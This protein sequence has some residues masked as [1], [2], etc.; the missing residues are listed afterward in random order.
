VAITPVRECCQNTLNLALSEAPR[1][2]TTI[3]VGEM[4]DKLEDAQK[5]LLLSEHYMELLQTTASIMAAKSLSDKKVHEFISE[6]LPVPENAGQ[7]QTN[8]IDLIR[9]D[10]K[11]RYQE[12]PDLQDMPKNAWRLINA[13]SDAATHMKPLRRT[14][15]YLENM[16]TKT[17]TEGNPLIDKAYELLRAV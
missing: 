16:F 13:V 12:A 7:A 6:L 9:T 17:V 8:N 1:T 3:H 4:K 11:L 2:W 15:T 10:I 14:E 5:T